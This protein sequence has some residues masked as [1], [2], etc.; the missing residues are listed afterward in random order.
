[1]SGGGGV[2]IRLQ[3]S[4][5]LL[6]WSQRHCSSPHHLLPP[7][8]PPP[9]CP[10]NEAASSMFF[11]A[12]D[13]ISLSSRRHSIHVSIHMSQVHTSTKHGVR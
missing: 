8:P 9:P 5:E 12:P 3:R 1:M 13:G 6:T 10:L 11:Q 4:V 7:L 2:R